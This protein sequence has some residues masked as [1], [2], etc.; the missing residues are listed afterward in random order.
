M[1]SIKVRIC[2]WI[3]HTNQPTIPLK[4]PT[5]ANMSVKWLTPGNSPYSIAYTTRT[6]K[7]PLKRLQ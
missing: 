2:W 4:R 6:T 1:T 7:V 3:W 5:N